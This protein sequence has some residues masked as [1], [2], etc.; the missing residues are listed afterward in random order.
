L[1]LRLHP[2]G[3]G[4]R[5][6]KPVGNLKGEGGGEKR[7]GEAERGPDRLTGS[8]REKRKIQSPG[9]ISK[10]GGRK[11]TSEEGDAT[12]KKKSTLTPKEKKYEGGSDG[13]KT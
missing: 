13:A 6:R 12:G 3:F 5:T 10:E 1:G 7:T 4:Q 11:C 8:P 9:K 2:W